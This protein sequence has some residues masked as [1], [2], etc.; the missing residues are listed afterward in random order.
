MNTA[1]HVTAR[2]AE[3]MDPLRGPFGN[4]RPT[5][6]LSR[7]AMAER[8]RRNMSRTCSARAR[9]S[10]QRRSRC[11]DKDPLRVAGHRP[12]E[13]AK[14]YM[15]FYLESS[16]SLITKNS[17]SEPSRPAPFAFSTVVVVAA[18]GGGIRVVRRA[19][20][21]KGSEAVMKQGEFAAGRMKTES[22]SSAAISG[23]RWQASH[24]HGAR[25]HGCR[26]AS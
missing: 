3:G 24:H 11:I 1:R 7:S 12:W 6:R 10:P 25:I 14:A 26:G 5:S 19:G 17:S 18:G 22:G 4:R 15:C 9:Y 2:M 23:K 20:Q 16:A 13:E 8:S 21:L